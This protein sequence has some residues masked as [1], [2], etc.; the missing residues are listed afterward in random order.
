M[1]WWQDDIR[2]TADALTEPSIHREPIRYWDRNRNPRE[3]FY[4][5]VQPGLLTQLYQ[6]VLPSWSASDA[7]VS[8][9]HPGSRP[10]LAIEALSTYQEIAGLVDAWCA[11]L[12]LHA[13]GGAESRIRHLAGKAMSF[14][15]VAGRTLLADLRR[16]RRWCLVMTGWEKVVALRQVPCPESGCGQPGLRVN[17]TVG[18]A[19]CRSCGAAWAR[20]DERLGSLDRLLDYV[21][22]AVIRGA[23]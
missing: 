10:P 19:F 11:T 2:D 14:D 9:G 20:D 21:E 18:S 5:T 7:P 23:A 3:R 17:L 12:G 13:R 1:T 6:S 15:E 16:W 22:K 8:G 4:Q